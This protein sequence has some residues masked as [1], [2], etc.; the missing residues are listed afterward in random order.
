[1]KVSTIVDLYENKKLYLIAS[2]INRFTIR[3]VIKEGR[4]IDIA[5]ELIDLWKPEG[6]FQ[7]GN[8]LQL[9]DL[10]LT[11]DNLKKLLSRILKNKGIKELSL[12]KNKL[13]DEGILL[14]CDSIN[15]HPENIT[16]IWLYGNNITELSRKYL[17]NLIS[18][19]ST[20]KFISI[21]NKDSGY[22][23]YDEIKNYKK[24]EPI[25]EKKESI[26]EPIVVEPDYKRMYFD[27]L[28]E[29]KSLIVN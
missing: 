6:G 23:N 3:N 9:C 28:K 17:H 7:L 19:N 8:Y 27:L 14:L 22:N 13:T 24:E 29:V 1:M 25:V 16:T 4:Y 10:E 26:I 21:N 15:N 2:E 11:D 18:F 5:C 20:L 12:T